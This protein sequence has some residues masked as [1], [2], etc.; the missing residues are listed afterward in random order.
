MNKLKDI[1]SRVC[2]RGQTLEIPAA[3][4]GHFTPNAH[5]LTTVVVNGDTAKVFPVHVAPCAADICPGTAG[6]AQ[7]LY[8]FIRRMLL[9]CEGKP[10]VDY[11]VLFDIAVHG[12]P[13]YSLDCR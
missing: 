12:N 3:L 9:G 7:R 1:V 6:Q 2:Q 11:N 10:I 8:H 4:T 5:I 13:P